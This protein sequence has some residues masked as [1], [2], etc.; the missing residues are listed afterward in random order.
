MQEVSSLADIMFYF[1][2]SFI[3]YMMLF[4]IIIINVIKAIYIR[5]YPMVSNDKKVKIKDII[6]NVLCGI[7][8]YCNIFFVGV[9]AD[10]NAP[11]I[12]EWASV[13]L[14]IAF[15]SLIVFIIHILIVFSPNNKG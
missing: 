15:I 6:I 14:V 3:G 10:N 5:R 8:M 4:G 7:A 1:K 2:Y 9:L 13:M 11:H 12:R